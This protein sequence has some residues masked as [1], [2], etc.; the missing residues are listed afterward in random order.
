MSSIRRERRDPLP[1]T[2]ELPAAAALAWVAVAAILLPAGRGAASWLTG[3]GWVWP[4]TGPGLTAS[5]AG[6]LAGHPSYG[7]SASTATFLPADSVVYLLVA[8]VEL[9]WLIVSL[10][11]LRAWWRT[12]GPGMREG[13]ADRAEVEKVLGLSRMRRNRNVI[14]PDLYG[15]SK[16]IGRRS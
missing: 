1:L 10:L 7:L 8:L 16:T 11:V 14:R 3:G 12:W 6:L 15:K 5:L 9:A 2:W 13:L 4:E